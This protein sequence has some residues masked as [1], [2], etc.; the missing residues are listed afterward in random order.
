MVM[1]LWPRFLAHPVVL[2]DS[3]NFNALRRAH[4]KLPT[5]MTAGIAV[6][7]MCLEIIVVGIII[8]IC[9][10]IP[11]RRQYMVNLW[12]ELSD[13]DWKIFCVIKQLI[14]AVVISATS[15]SHHSSLHFCNGMHCMSLL[16]NSTAKLRRQRF[17]IQWVQVPP[18][19]FFTL[20][21][22]LPCPFPAPHIW[23]KQ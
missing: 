21:L 8:E 18:S 9:L 20:L 5:M 7:D 14:A 16:V 23:R 1:S 11:W 19:P 10:S 12:R 3:H 22:P 6:R 15:L 4:W 13:G 2:P 17:I